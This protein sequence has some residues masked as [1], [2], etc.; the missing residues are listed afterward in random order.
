MGNI[1]F[2]GLYKSPQDL[3]YMVNF[4]N[5]SI[6]KYLNEKYDGNKYYVLDM[7]KITDKIPAKFAEYYASTIHNYIKDNLIDKLNTMLEISSIKKFTT[8]RDNLIKILD[9]V[10]FIL[11]NGYDVKI[12]NGKTYKSTFTT[13]IDFYSGVKNC[14]DYI[15]DNTTKM[16]SKLDTSINFDN[17]IYNDKSIQDIIYTLYYDDRTK[18]I[19]TLGTGLQTPDEY[20]ILDGVNTK[21]IEV[22]Y[23]TKEVKIK[24]QKSPKPKNDNDIK[25]IIN[26][27][28]LDTTTD[29]IK[30]IFSGN[31]KIEN[32]L[33]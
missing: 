13:P 3:S 1:N 27:E 6:L 9:K 30:E 7:L 10:K 29:E 4:T 23:K 14:I 33:T 20:Q 24:F 18:I 21:L 5:S 26:S 31:I 12:D 16:Y 32:K 11:D 8:N 28:I 2:F 17:Q 22:F 25:Y 15:T 19:G